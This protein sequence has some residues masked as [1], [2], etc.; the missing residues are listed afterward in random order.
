ME[1]VAMHQPPDMTGYLVGNLR[2]IFPVVAPADIAFGSIHAIHGHDS[3]RK[4]V[5]FIVVSRLR[6]CPYASMTASRRI[7]H[8]WPATIS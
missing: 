2:S 5:P 7:F 1:A 6:I 3:N 8:K 4:C